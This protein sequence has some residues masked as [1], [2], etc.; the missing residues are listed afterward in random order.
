MRIPRFAAAVVAAALLL[1]LVAACGDDDDDT[2]GSTGTTAASGGGGGGELSAESFTADFS[3]MAQLKDL[4]AKG[5]GKIAVLLPDTTTS[6]RYEA[7]DR[8]YL[9]QAFEAAGLTSNDYIINN[10]QGSAST[11]QTQ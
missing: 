3:A 8:P 11:M 7:F 1:T 10:A 4:A 6:A 5:K 2:S 9:Q